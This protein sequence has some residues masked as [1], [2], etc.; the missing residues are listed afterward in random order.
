MPKLTKSFIDKYPAPISKDKFEWDT[1]LKVSVFELP[2]KVVL[3]LLCKTVLMVARN[4]LLSGSMVSLPLT[5]HVTLPASIYA[6]CAWVQAHSAG[7]ST[8]INVYYVTR[9]LRLLH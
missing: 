7:K 1:E 9:S 4:V 3:A 8:C 6:Q 5:K 2:L